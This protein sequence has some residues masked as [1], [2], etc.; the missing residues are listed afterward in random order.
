MDPVSIIIPVYNRAV[1]T[2]QC[3]EALMAPPGEAVEHE[4]IVVDDAS[5]DMTPRLLRSYGSRIHVVTHGENLGFAC[6]CNDGAAAASG[7]LLIFLNNDTIPIRGWL[8]ALVAYADVHQ[9]ASVVGSKL[10]FPNET[11]QHAGVVISQDAL[12]RHLYAGFPADHPAVNK[13]RRFQMVTAACMLVRRSAFEQVG[14]FDT[15]FRNG[16]EDVDLCLRLGERGHEI[17]YCHK[18]VL[19]HLESVSDG[20][21]SHGADNTRLYTERW[22]ERVQRDELQ[23][24]LEDGLLRLHYQKLYPIGFEVSPLLGLHDSDDRAAEAD[25][26]LALRARQVEQLVSEN[27]G[28]RIHLQEATARLAGAPLGSPGS[29]A[30]GPTAVPPDERVADPGAVLICRGR[31]RNGQ[32]PGSGRLVSIAIPVKN[33]GDHLRALLAR[34]SEQQTQDDVEIVA[35]DSG[36]TDTSVAMLQAAGATVWAIPPESFNHGLTRNLAARC[37]EGD[38]VVFVNQGAL[39]ADGDWL[40]N[41]V[42]PLDADSRLAGVCSRVIPS[43]SAD[44]LQRQEGLRAVSGSPT[45][46]LR[47]IDDW[48]AFRSLSSYELR[49]FINFHTVSA[50]FRPRILAQFPFRRVTSIGEDV[51]WAKDV[52]E[53]GYRI[54]HEPTSVVYHSHDYGYLDILRRNVDDGLCNQEIVGRQLSEADVVPLITAMVREDWR[55]LGENGQLDAEELERWRLEAVL[56]RAAQVLGQAIGL[57]ESPLAASLRPLLSLVASLRSTATEQPGER[58]GQ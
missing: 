44:L 34:I 5:A 50:A 35:V 37:C 7:R 1:I 10:L 57:G 53:A 31:T 56:R 9:S 16:Y 30:T 3:L 27:T 25:R 39:P 47:Q 24:Y 17:H 6:A 38:V 52:L 49:L 48:R 11:I 4:I 15:A 45:R 8:E 26:L 29:V 22:A 41:L 36:S 55:Y 19:Y 54:Q 13:S 46:V 14:G 2:R 32:R 28:L 18:S 40:R 51:L 21:W 20:R 42:A 12:P 58:A 23:Y 33:G 43:P